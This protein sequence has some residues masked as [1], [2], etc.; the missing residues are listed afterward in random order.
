MHSDQPHSVGNASIRAPSEHGG[1]P[2]GFLEEAMYEWA[3]PD[4][5]SRLTGVGGHELQNSIILSG[6]GFPLYRSSS[7]WGD[8]GVWAELLS[9]HSQDYSQ[10]QVGWSGAV[11]NS[12]GSDEKG[13]VRRGCGT[14]LQSE[15]IS[16]W[17]YLAFPGGSE[18]M[19]L[20]V[21]QETWG[22]AGSIPGS[23]RSPGGGRRG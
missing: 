4:F 13:L 3:F 11:E 16:V 5:E 14:R 10:G 2:E 21:M 23:G 17:L 20:P 6:Q 22:H 19:N 12:P 7:R 9:D 1:F 8:K 18:V 15:L